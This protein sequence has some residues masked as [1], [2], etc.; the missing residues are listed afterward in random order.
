ML[1][2][3]HFA[4]ILS[5]LKLVSHILFIKIMTVFSSDKFA[6]TDMPAAD[7]RRSLGFA[8]A[9]SEPRTEHTIYLF[10][11]TV[12]SMISFNRYT[13][14]AH[15]ICE[16]TTKILPTKN[17]CQSY[18]NI[19]IRI[20]FFA[21]SQIRNKRLQAAFYVNLFICTAQHTQTLH[22]KATPINSF[23]QSAIII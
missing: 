5:F 14:G 17:L 13:C 20:N 12:F 1:K 16:C 11:F 9:P 10:V 7:S 3:S 21:P 19:F 15:L 2:N 4:H 6:T 18:N 8:Q 22:S 23:I